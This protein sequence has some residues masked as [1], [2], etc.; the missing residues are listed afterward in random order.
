[1]VVAT[2]TR[3]CM[4]AEKVPWGFGVAVW[5]TAQRG[6]TALTSSIWWHPSRSEKPFLLQR[7]IGFTVLQIRCLLTGSGN[8]HIV[9]RPKLRNGEHTA[10]P[11]HPVSL[12]AGV[13]GESFHCPCELGVLPG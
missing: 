10:G 1:M 4:L 12:R 7:R 11:H 5:L 13:I 6:R 3:C 9:H 8:P 2:R